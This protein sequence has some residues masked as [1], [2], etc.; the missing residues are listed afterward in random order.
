MNEDPSRIGTLTQP[1]LRTRLLCVA[2]LAFVVL[3]AHAGARERI[4]LVKMTNGDRL[5]CEIIHLQ[6]AALNVRTANVGTVTIDWPD[7]AA[8]ISSQLFEVELVDGRRIIGSLGET[9]TSGQVELR[10]RT[11]GS[12]IL[13]LSDVTGI[14]QLG[15]TIW[16]SRRGY[17]D[18][19][20]DY[21]S[22][23]ESTQISVGAE[24]NL[25]G[26]RFRWENDLSTTLSNDAYSPQRMRNL[27]QTALEI[28]L[29]RKWVARAVTSY[30][31]NDD[32]D[33][34]SRV[35]G[36]ALA[37]WYPKVSARG[38]WGVGGGIVETR[39]SYFGE[40]ASA[41]STLATLVATGDY[42]RFGAFGTNATGELAWLPVLDG[43]GR[44]RLELRG[45]VRQKIFSDFSISLSPYLSYDSRPPQSEAKQQDWGWVSSV[46]WNF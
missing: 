15:S 29:G 22:A 31:S 3:A 11:D 7:V 43:S 24:F 16:D 46:G 45:S 36:A 8:L 41:N 9:E 32:L 6:S 39:E 19:G 17:L 28:P 37:I 2:L 25:Q 33:L 42:D 14:V 13:Q 34:D 5:T 10:T 23:G 38:R 21:S 18:F 30:E 12:L 1:G 20:F 4:D 40:E 26:P 35:S 44:Y 27:L